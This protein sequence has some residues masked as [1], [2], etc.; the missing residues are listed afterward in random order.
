MIPVIYVFVIVVT[1]FRWFAQ[2][3]LSLHKFVPS[4]G[5]CYRSYECTFADFAVATSDLAIT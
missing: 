5:C 4:R 3:S 1:A 2:V